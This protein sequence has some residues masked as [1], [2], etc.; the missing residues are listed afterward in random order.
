MRPDG[1]PAAHLGDYGIAPETIEGDALDALSVQ[2]IAIAR[3][4]GLY[5]VTEA[6]EP[7]APNKD[8]TGNRKVASDKPKPSYSDETPATP[9]VDAEPATEPSDLES[10]G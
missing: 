2:Q 8:K 7:K 1:Q 10:A 6:P 3:D 4:S 5:R 9:P